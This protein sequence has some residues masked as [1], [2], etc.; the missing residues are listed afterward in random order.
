VENIVGTGVQVSFF[1][2]LLSTGISLVVVIGVP[3]I[4]AGVGLILEYAAL[5]ILKDLQA[6]KGL[7]LFEKPPGAELQTLPRAELELNFL[8][9]DSARLT[10]IDDEIRVWRAIH[11]CMRVTTKNTRLWG[12]FL[13]LTIIG[14]NVI[15]QRSIYDKTFF[16]WTGVLQG[17]AKTYIQT[18]LPICPKL[19]VSYVALVGSVIVP[20]VYA[21]FFVISSV[22]S[23]SRALLKEKRVVSDATLGFILLFLYMSSSYSF[24]YWLSVSSEEGKELPAQTMVLKGA[25]TSLR[26]AFLVGGYAVSPVVLLFSWVKGRLQSKNQ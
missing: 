4:I 7:L 11:Y 23:L 12:F 17:T 3:L 6:E 1:Q 18:Y 16:E 25:K 8:Q 21:G 14:G 9:G 13:M 15:G 20:G 5:E 26:S 10:Q 24:E 22:H 2:S 19:L